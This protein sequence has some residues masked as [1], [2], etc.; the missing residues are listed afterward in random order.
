M[1]P[2]SALVNKDSDIPADG[3]LPGSSEE[4]NE[5]FRDLS[6]TLGDDWEV[7]LLEGVEGVT[8]PACRK[9]LDQIGINREMTEAFALLDQA[10]GPGITAGE[11]QQIVSPDVLEMSSILSADCS[12]EMVA[13]CQ[14]RASRQGWKG[15][16]EARVLDAQQSHLPAESFSH[17]TMS[18]GFHVIPDAEAA[19]NGDYPFSPPRRYH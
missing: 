14:R 19:L 1:I 13:A 16:C 8:A 11:V 17:V 6:K 10:C 2:I 5:I 7:R 18:L 9:M 12:A 3:S 4:L 15:K